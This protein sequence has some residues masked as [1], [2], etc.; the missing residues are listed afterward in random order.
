MGVMRGSKTLLLGALLC[1]SGLLLGGVSK[2][3]YVS[4]APSTKSDFLSAYNPSAV[5]RQFD[6]PRQTRS[7]AGNAAGCVLPWDRRDVTHEA[8][9][10]WWLRTPGLPV[11]AALFQDTRQALT[12]SGATILSESFADG[13]F[14]IRYRAGRITGV[15][16]G[17]SREGGSLI[18]SVKESFAI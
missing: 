4:P 10:E 17:G 18:W 14:A 5:V 3:G 12:A 9:Y 15:V 16:L 11:I 8:G 2:F 7:S 6:L 1:A 13:R